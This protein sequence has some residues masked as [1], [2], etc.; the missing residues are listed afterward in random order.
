MICFVFYLEKS[1]LTNL[2]PASA[3]PQNEMQSRNALPD[4]RETN[5]SCYIPRQ[6]LEVLMEKV[7]EMELVCFGVQMQLSLVNDTHPTH[8]IPAI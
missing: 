5:S 6:A 7:I 8:Q 3:E 2:F 4:I 1:N